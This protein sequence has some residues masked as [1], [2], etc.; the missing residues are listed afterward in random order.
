M[1]H[2]RIIAR[3]KEKINSLYKVNLINFK[4]FRGFKF[5]A[6][7]LNANIF[8]E[9]HESTFKFV[10]WKKP[11]IHFIKINTDGSVKDGLYGCGGI[12]RN[13]KGNLVMAFATPLNKCS[14]LVAELK[15]IYEALKIC[16]T[17]GY[18]KIWLEIDALIS[19]K[20]ISVEKKGNFETFYIIKD[21][22]RMLSHLD[23]KISHIW[24]EGNSATDFLAKTGS[25]LDHLTLF[26]NNNIPF[27]LKGIINLDKTGL[28]YI[29]V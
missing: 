1:N 26:H 6:N 24:R 18:W 4:Q 14:V 12:L 28:P 13:D 23:Y 8:E 29:R 3:T 17:F 27:L 19:I 9:L 16:L 2:N 21:I 7:K 22:K 5:V 20:E 10:I 25:K 11:D 15:A